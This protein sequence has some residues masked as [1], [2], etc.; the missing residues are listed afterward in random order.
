[1]KDPV[2]SLPAMCLFNNRLYLTTFTETRMK[3]LSFYLILLLTVISLACSREK[4]IDLYATTDVHGLLLPYDNTEEKVID[5]SMANLAW[6]Q[7][8]IGKDKMVLLDNGDILQGDPLVY[9]YNFVDTTSPHIVATILNDLGY[10]AATI[11]NHDI[12]TGHN[13]Y[14][15]VKRE[16]KFPLLAA[17]AIDEKTGM[18]Y[19]KPYTTIMRNG[20][21]VLI[22][23]L[24]TPAVPT[25]L[26]P[27]M[28]KGMRFE[29]MVETAK[30]W[31]PEM[32]KEKPDIIVGL[33]HSGMGSEKNTSFDE[34]SSLAVAENVPGFDVIFIGHDHDVAINKIMNVSGDSVLILDGGSRSSYLM[35]ASVKIQAGKREKQIKGNLIRMNSIP[36]DNEFIE[37]YKAVSDTI[38]EYTGRTIGFSNYSADTRDSFFGPSAFVDLIH[39]IQISVSGAEISF[40]APLSFDARI[41]S[42]YLHV[43]D[44][45]KLYRFENFLYTVKMKGSEIDSYLEHSYG[46]WMNTMKNSSDYMLEYKLDDN[47][48]PVMI[49]GGARLRN[50]SYNFDSAW[51]IVY[52]VD[53]TKEA[54]NRVNISRLINGKPFSNDSFYLVAVNSYRANGGGGH[55]DA[56]G[57]THEMLPQRIVA[58]TSRDLR[59]Y[60]TEWIE[61]HNR[62]SPVATSK[63]VVKPEMW[64][65]NAKERETV[66]LFGNKK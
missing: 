29:N 61:A 2:R 58:T 51:G 46:K 45:F 50:P 60:M 10:D 7:D 9:Y 11:G 24:I 43:S 40:A 33:F 1:M 66:L 49:N 35:H 57:I 31:M 20:V 42:G 6:L 62:L 63:W 39:E 32:K 30:K 37:K 23:G 53:L 18:P 41:D 55:F 19:F 65:K 14:D 44:M 16:Y 52:S 27:S 15:R 64:V 47:G 13:V 34:N 4:T 56:A 54:G 12:E 21:K 36:P 59:Y 38:K 17:N 5:H 48:S 22:F 3:R 25:W 26:P 28:Y 8:S